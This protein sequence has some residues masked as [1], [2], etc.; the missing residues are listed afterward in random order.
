MIVFLSLD[1][2]GEEGDDCFSDRQSGS[3]GSTRI[4]LTIE[5]VEKERKRNEKD[6][7]DLFRERNLYHSCSVISIRQWE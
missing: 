7:I 3:R 2:G 1:D 6:C 4:L 5:M